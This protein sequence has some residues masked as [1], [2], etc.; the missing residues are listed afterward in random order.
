VRRKISLLSVNFSQSKNFSVRELFCP[1]QI[2]RKNL[3]TGEKFFMQR[4][5]HSM[6]LI[7]HSNS[8]VDINYGLAFII[9]THTPIAVSMSLFIPSYFD[10]Q[11]SCR[12]KPNQIDFRGVFVFDASQ[13]RKKCSHLFAAG[14]IICN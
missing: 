4:I 10:Q 14:V 11:P 6:S 7:V 3:L 2:A 1:N 12:I 13:A 9:N 5:F 8:C